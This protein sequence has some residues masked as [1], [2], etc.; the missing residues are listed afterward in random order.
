MSSI[1][2]SKVFTKLP[3]NQDPRRAHGQDMISICILQIRDLTNCILLDVIFKLW[4][5]KR[6]FQSELKK[7]TSCQFI[8]RNK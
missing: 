2:F 4:V 8:K 6:K 1:I 5:K 7:K 3:Q